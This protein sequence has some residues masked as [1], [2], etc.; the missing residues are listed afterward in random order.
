[1]GFKELA[2]KAEENFDFA[3]ALEYYEKALDELSVEDGSL[4]RYAD[5]LFEFQE[6]EKAREVFEKLVQI[7]DK[8]EY[9]E[10]LAQIYEELNLKDKAVGIYQKLGRTDKV[11]EV[12]S[13][14]SEINDLVVKK[15]LE[16]F[17]GREDVF[18]VQT[19]QG[20][21]PV[22]LPMREKDVIEHLNKE[23]TLGVYVLRSDNCIKFAAFDVDFKK[24]AV[25][26]YKEMLDLCEQTVKR[27]CE[28]LRLENIE[29]H[30]EFSGN[31]GYHV[32]IFFDRWLQA[33]KV[34]FV[35]NKIADEVEKDEKIS[36][37]VFPKQS[38]TGGGLGNLI[39]L[40]LG[41]HRKT[42]NKCVFVDEKFNPFPDQFGYLLKI[43]PIDS[44]DFE[45]KY[46][47]LSQEQSTVKTRPKQA[48][49][50]NKTETNKTDLKKALRR[51]INSNTNYLKMLFQACYVLK[52]LG[53]K[54]EKFGYINEDEEYIVVASCA[55]ADGSKEF[56]AELLEKTIN[57]SQTKLYSL[58]NRAG[59]L[60]LT[61]EEI[62][63]IIMNKSLSISIEQCNCKFNEPFNTPL[64]LVSNSMFFLSE[65]IDV[66]DIIKKIM[67]KIKEKTEIENQIKTL[68]NLLA[69]KMNC[70]ELNVGN[71]IIRKNGEDIQIII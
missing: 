56:L 2:L 21:Y 40:P 9:L 1:M 61:C 11:K 15:F 65:N 5:L 62:K 53:E 44:D 52:Q 14:C 28:R 34:R 31:R 51:E 43:Q 66:N 38:E 12:K 22:R 69:L 54:I 46:S 67:D 25:E 32:W 19:D 63:R 71:V 10:K 42:M 3:K 55:C 30:V 39:K 37:E 33:Y 17:S 64:C 13:K 48:S 18:A 47:E 35:L 36:I 8:E 24:S 50:T 7:T 58:I 60:P 26:G 70:D 49:V 59:T 6:Y 16:L 45:K 29:Y 68:K 23:K 4:Q 57:Y 27:L 41:I 20:Y